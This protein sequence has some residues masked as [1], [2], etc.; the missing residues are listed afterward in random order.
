[1]AEEGRKQIAAKDYPAAE[2]TFTQ[3]L[4]IGPNEAW[5]YA[6]RCTVKIV[7]GQFDAASADCEQALTLDAKDKQAR[8]DR[9]FLYLR[10]NQYDLAA[11]DC[12]A[13]LANDPQSAV[14]LNYL[15]Q[16]SQARVRSPKIQGLS[17]GDS[18]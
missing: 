9:A 8:L 11:E 16:I 1:M 15:D 10:R 13:V 2:A 17:N 3:A 18:R 14:A 5:L 6:S 7:S 12:N 4:R